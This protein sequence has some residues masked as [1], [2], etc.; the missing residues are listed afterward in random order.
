MKFLQL[1]VSNVGQIP[2]AKLN[3]QSPVTYIGGPN[4]SGKSTLKLAMQYAFTEKVRDCKQIK[5]SFSLRSNGAD[6]AQVLL[7][8]ENSDGF[9][10]TLQRSMPSRKGDTQERLDSPAIRI[11][12]DPLWFI[13]LSKQER[14]NMLSEIVGTDVDKAAILKQ[15]IHE[16]TD[17]YGE[18]LRIILAENEKLDWSDPD[19]I[20]A[21]VISV[22]QSL[23][24]ER[25]PLF[26]KNI[27]VAANYGADATTVEQLNEAIEEQQKVANE[28]EKKIS[29]SQHAKSLQEEIDGNIKSIEEYK[30]SMD[31]GVSAR[32]ASLSEKIEGF[33]ANEKAFETKLRLENLIKTGQDEIEECQAEIKDI[34]VDIDQLEK[35]LAIV[36]SNIDM[37]SKARD[38]KLCPICGSS[39]LKKMIDEQLR[40]CKTTSKL[41][42]TQIKEWK[43]V[44]ENNELL[45]DMVA[46]R[47][48][49]Q[50][51]TEESA[52]EVAKTK[53]QADKLKIA[54]DGKDRL[55]VKAE[56]N[57]KL[58]RAIDICEGLMV[59]YKDSLSKIKV[60]ELPEN[61][62]E[63]INDGNIEIENIKG[64]RQRRQLFEDAENV[65]IAGQDRK[66]E[67]D[68][69]IAET[70]RLT[71]LL[72]AG[73]IVREEINRSGK[74]IPYNTKLAEAW[75]LRDFS[76]SD[77][78][79]FLCSS[80][81]LMKDGVVVA[82]ESQRY[83]IAALVAMALSEVA[84]VGFVVLDGV[85][86]LDS[87]NVN[88]LF[89]CVKDSNLESIVMF[90]T[91]TKDLSDMPKQD[92]LSVYQLSVNKSRTYVKEVS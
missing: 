35:D 49:R 79:S 15:E 36:L 31:N 33:E 78:G 92:W 41:I 1:A 75:G 69:Q 80:Q 48:V 51:E 46:N 18:I 6:L 8:H 26:E 34:P 65:H 42:A 64:M 67:L 60:V 20:E 4:G 53:S 39:I 50:F 19:A 37:L 32:I 81:T 54:R 2:R 24:R 70:D 68:S 21:A 14:A 72:T 76:M 66:E 29:D 44:M 86:I 55:E 11:A 52:R 12:L 84:G 30:S 9:P 27:P 57:E 40:E 38:A 7:T 23:K 85:D 62:S 82:S 91:T 63:I 22:R 73:G 87:D 3:L 88:T 90:G 71:G 45:S 58:Q 83:R 61:A 74:E 10:E 16:S 43:P 13:G 25:E 56:K 17:V 5:Q 77:D 47:K 28:L 59:Q 89:K